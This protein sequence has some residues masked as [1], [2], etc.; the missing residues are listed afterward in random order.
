MVEWMIGVFGFAVVVVAPCVAL[1]LRKRVEKR[2]R[3]PLT[4]S[5]IDGLMSSAEFAVIE[6]G[7]SLNCTRPM[8]HFGLSDGRLLFCDYDRTVRFPSSD[9]PEEEVFALR[10]ANHDGELKAR[11]AKGILGLWQ[12]PSED[13]L[14]G[15]VPGIDPCI[16][17]ELL[18][19]FL[20]TFRNATKT[21][22]RAV[23]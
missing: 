6:R 22:K 3:R 20:Q 18:G 5:E 23:G 8:A 17:Q 21:H 16:M 12:L 11:F 4:L 14:H 15:P 10:V 1:F 9:C 2:N 7:P 13:F 19:S